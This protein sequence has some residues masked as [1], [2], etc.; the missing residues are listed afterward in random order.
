MLVHLDH[1]II[2][3]MSVEKHLDC[4]RTVL[5]ELFRVYV[6]LKLKECFFFEYRS[7]G[8]HNHG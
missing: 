1:V 4:L 5:E 3:S 8:S 2:F 6:S 7:L